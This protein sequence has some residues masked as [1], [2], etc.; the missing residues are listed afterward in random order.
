MDAPTTPLLAASPGGMLAIWHDVA[1]GQSATVREWYGREHHFERL[2]IPGFME[3]RRFDRVAGTGAEIFGAYRITAPEVLNS[4]A[5]RARVDAPSAWTREAMLHFRNMSRTVCVITGRAGHAQ[6]GFLAALASPHGELVDAPATCDQLMSRPGVLQVTALAG[7][8]KAPVASST[9]QG[10]RSGPDAQI[11]WALLFDTDS[12]DAGKRVLEAA[13][14]LTNC[15]Q[16]V[17]AAV[18]RLCFAARNPLE[19]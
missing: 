18:Y 9:E 12:L 15:R 7:E 16:P 19:A 5:Y 10:L 17:Q 8:R 1:P 2:A 11:A 4:D 14:S 3:A 6:G 13:Q